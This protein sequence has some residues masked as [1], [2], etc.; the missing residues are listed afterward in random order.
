L[1]TSASVVKLTVALGMFAVNVLSWILAEQAAYAHP[2][3]AAAP[4]AI[5]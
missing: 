2:S 4:Q 1:F 5:K 3:Q